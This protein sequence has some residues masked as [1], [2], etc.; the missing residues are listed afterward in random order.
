M[1]GSNEGI[2]AGCERFRGGCKMCLY[3]L[4][5]L[6]FLVFHCDGGVGADL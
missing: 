6:I 2:S 5:N 1:E 3:H 4:K